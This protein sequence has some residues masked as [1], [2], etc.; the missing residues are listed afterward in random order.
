MLIK[1]TCG[2]EIVRLRK[3]EFD[4]QKKLLEEAISALNLQLCLTSFSEEGV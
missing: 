1:L 3:Q 2:Q 4:L